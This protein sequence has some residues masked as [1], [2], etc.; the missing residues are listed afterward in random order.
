MNG[1]AVYWICKH[2]NVNE[3]IYFDSRDDEIKI[4]PKP[5]GVDSKGNMSLCLYCNGRD[6]SAV[7]IW[8]KEKGV[9]EYSWKE[10]MT[11]ENLKKPVRSFEPICF[12][13]N[14]I[15][16]RLDVPTAST[17]VVYNPCEKRLKNLLPRI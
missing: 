2:K 16:I 6:E 11:V 9:H 13:E 14:K 1:A 12:V 8:E 4:L 7:E 5:K 15:A 3:I 17:L 10:L